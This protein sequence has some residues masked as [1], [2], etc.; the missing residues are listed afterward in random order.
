MARRILKLATAAVI[1]T[2]VFIVGTMAL[3]D[4]FIFFPSSELEGV[5][6]DLGLEYQD[7]FFTS[8]GQRLH[9]WFVPG[10]KDIT[11]LWTHGNGGNISHRL[12]NIQ[13]IHDKL[14]ISIFIFDYRGYGRSE[15]KPSEQGTYNDAQVALAYL[16]TIP[17]IEGDSFVLYGRSLGAAVAV[18]LATREPNAISGLILESPFVSIPAMAKRAYPF[19]PVGPFL[20]TRYDS[21]SKIGKTSVPLLVLHSPEDEIVPYDQGRELFEAAPEPK[22]FHT[23]AGGGHNE[24]Y[25]TGGDA[26][27]QALGQ[28][29]NGLR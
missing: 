11:W 17:A 14:G 7:I 28:F 13:L 27:W 6:S 2:I 23:I 18:E 1:I 9:G 8:E 25:I 4:K 10:S 20:R 12:E 26:Y 21:L 3:E 24:T 5:P 19:L 15:G 29:L 16:K 22:T